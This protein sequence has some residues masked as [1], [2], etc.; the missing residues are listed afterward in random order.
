MILEA[1]D[2]D[3][4]AAVPAW[5]SRAALLAAVDVALASLEG[6][7]ERKRLAVKPS[8]IRAVALADALTADRRTGARVATSNVTVAA[9]A[10]VSERVAERARAWLL[11]V[12]LAVEIARGRYLTAAER[13]ASGQIRAA[14]TRALTVPDRFTPDAAAIA[15]HVRAL[16]GPRRPRKLAIYPENSRSLKRSVNAHSP[17]SGASKPLNRQIQAAGIDAVLRISRNRHIGSLVTILTRSNVPPDMSAARILETIADVTADTGRRILSTFETRDPLGYFRWLLGYVF[18]MVEPVPE[19]TRP[20]R[21]RFDPVS[22]YCAVCG[23]RDDELEP[24]DRREMVG[25]CPA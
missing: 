21:H 5:P 19:R 13:A 4:A 11:R 10:G 1:V 17:R 22:G 18:G 8:K 9:A 16:R 20:H 23:L 2:P 7:T 15:R 25:T 3:A 6:D 14:S 24:P 12:G